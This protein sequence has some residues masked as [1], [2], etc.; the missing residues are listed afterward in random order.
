MITDTGKV[1]INTSEPEGAFTVWDDDSEL[2]IRRYKKKNM[3]IG[4]MRDTDLSLGTNGDIKLAIR[5]DG[6]VEM[7][8]IELNGLKISVSDTVPSHQGLPGELVLMSHA[9]EDEPWAYRCISG[10]RWKAIK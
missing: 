8:S 1:G 6:T 9:S 7:R 2:T 4:T 10:D 3:Y 5:K